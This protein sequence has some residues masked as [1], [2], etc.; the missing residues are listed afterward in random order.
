M[1]HGVRTW[2]AS[3]AL[4][5]D[6]DSFTYQVLHNGLYQASAGGPITVYISG[7]SPS[8]CSAVI[9]PTEPPA[10]DYIY[11]ALPYVS[12]GEGV[13]NVYGKHPAEA[14]RSLG[15]TIKFRLLVMRYKN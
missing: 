8:N 12:V 10:N 11:S 3:G 6:T 9:L 2:S 14:D 1:S 7:F 13:V 4:E 15:T 5:M